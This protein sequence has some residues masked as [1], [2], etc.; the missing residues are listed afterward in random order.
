MYTYASNVVKK[1]TKTFG[2]GKEQI[3]NSKVS[4]AYTYSRTTPSNRPSV[5]E[6]ALPSFSTWK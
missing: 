3:V 4:D 1:Q 5:N 6:T 2:F